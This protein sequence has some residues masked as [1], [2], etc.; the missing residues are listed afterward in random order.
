[1][2]NTICEEWKLKHTIAYGR[3]GGKVCFL[4]NEID[5]VPDIAN[6]TKRKLI[7]KIFAV[8]MIKCCATNTY[9][10]FYVFDSFVYF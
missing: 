7:Y 9:V 8:M 10:A 2:N 4:L 6:L 5:F 3:G 1:M